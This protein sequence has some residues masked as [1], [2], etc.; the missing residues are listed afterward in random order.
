MET[1]SCIRPRNEETITNSSPH[2]M[3][4]AIK[5]WMY[6][7]AIH[8]SIYQNFCK[9]N[10]HTYVDDFHLGVALKRI[11]CVDIAINDGEKM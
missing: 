4:E 3:K 10:I 1:T 5:V 8:S 6:D 9:Q 11:L 7:S 2:I